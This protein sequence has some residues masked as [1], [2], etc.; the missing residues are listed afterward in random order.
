MKKE[1]FY[2][3]IQARELLG[4][5]GARTMYRYIKDKKIK[6]TKI[7]YWKIKERDL[8]SFIRKHSNIRKK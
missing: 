3:L 4:G 2:T 7:G 6:A 8:E 5:I 1:N